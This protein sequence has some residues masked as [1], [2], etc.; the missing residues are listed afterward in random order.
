M[1]FGLLQ[2]SIHPLFFFVRASR[3]PAAP[4]AVAWIVATRRAPLSQRAAFVGEAAPR[5]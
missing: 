2:T 3:P 1:L 5:P 4:R